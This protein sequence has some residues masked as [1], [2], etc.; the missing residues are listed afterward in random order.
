MTVGR[1]QTSLILEQ[2][3]GHLILTT[4]MSRNVS[5]DSWRY[6]HFSETVVPY[7]FAHGVLDLTGGADIEK[8]IKLLVEA[9]DVCQFMNCSHDM[10]VEGCLT[11][12]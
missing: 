6:D 10:F 2:G 4:K 5:L 1:T 3:A 12:A 11:V 9:E 8:L 7:N